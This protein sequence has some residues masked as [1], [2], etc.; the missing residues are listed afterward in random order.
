MLCKLQF[1]NLRLQHDNID[2]VLPLLLQVTF[3]VFAL[4]LSPAF[5]PFFLYCKVH[6]YAR[7]LENK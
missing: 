4:E 7:H 1:N 2:I 3:S 5:N 6:A